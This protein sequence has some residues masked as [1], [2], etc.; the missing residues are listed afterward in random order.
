MFF[1]SNNMFLLLHDGMQRHKLR[2]VRPSK[3]VS[4][5][6]GSTV[7]RKILFAKIPLLVLLQ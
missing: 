5:S 4:A 6:M 7:S 1:F 2:Q 3:G